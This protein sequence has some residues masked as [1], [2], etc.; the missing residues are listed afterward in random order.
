MTKRDTFGFFV[1][2]ALSIATAGTA[3][4]TDFSAPITDQT[5]KPV[6]LCADKTPDC[7]KPMTLGRVVGIA[8]FSTFPDESDPRTGTAPSGEEKVK[9]A[10]LALEVFDGGQHDLTAEETALAKKLV[11][12]A[13]AP[14]VV[15]R[16]WE[17]LDPA[18]K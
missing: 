18:K 1:A 6:P 4:A 15:M 2:L 11:A 12:K 8:L 17:L 3:C 16:A 10:K 14:L 5:G 7:E 13:Y 9:R